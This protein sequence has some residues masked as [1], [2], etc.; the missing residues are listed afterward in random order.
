MIKKKLPPTVRALKDIC[1]FAS[2]VFAEQ[3]ML[4]FGFFMS[5][6]LTAN[7][8]T[9]AMAAHQVGMNAM[10]LSFS[11]GDGLQVAAVTLIGQSL[12]QGNKMLAKKYGNICQ[13]L[14]LAISVFLALLYLLFGRWFFGIYF[15]NDPYIVDL[16]VVI[17]KFMMLIVLFQ[18]SQVIFTGSLRGAGDVRF[19]TVTSMI[20]V[21]IIRPSVSYLAAYVLG[22]GI[23][24][25]WIGILADQGVRLIL[26]AGRFKSGRW[27]NKEI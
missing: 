15:P 25:I 22:L 24:G 13:T 9:E 18:V 7:L 19:T 14:G 6:L 4:R 2:T 11:F 5:A 23:T 3:L 20:S 27:M 16:G 26:N 1:S 21:A 10:H 8:G 12:G 17:M